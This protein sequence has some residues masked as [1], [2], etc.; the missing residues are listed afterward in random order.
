MTEQPSTTM[1]SSGA[2][3]ARVAEDFMVVI[4]KRPQSPSRKRPLRPCSPGVRNFHGQ[5]VD[6]AVRLHYHWDMKRGTDEGPWNDGIPFDGR[7]VWQLTLVAD[8]SK[9]DVW[10]FK[11]GSLVKLERDQFPRCWPWT[12]E[13]ELPYA[14]D[15]VDRFD[16]DMPDAL[17]LCVGPHGCE[18][19]HGAVHEHDLARAA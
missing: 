8:D 12:K 15:G 16:A 7:D 3:F 10:T 14:R 1:P 11:P 17:P 2:T 19:D 6:C 18:D 9:H 5:E 4:G 13:D